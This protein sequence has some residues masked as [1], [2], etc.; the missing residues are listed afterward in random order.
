MLRHLLS[1]F[2]LSRF[3]CRFLDL[4]YQPLGSNEYEESIS[5]LSD[6]ENYRR[7]S[8]DSDSDSDSD[9]L[10][11]EEQIYCSQAKRIKSQN[12]QENFEILYE[13]HNGF[14]S[15]QVSIIENAL[16]IVVDRLFKPEILQNMYQICGKSN[17]FLIHGVL[18]QSN[19]IENSIYF[20]QYL[21]LHYQLMCLKVQCENGEMPIINIY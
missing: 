11:N 2:C 4:C 3:K 8:Y 12:S 17:C 19:L 14:T 13:I 9:I 5:S 20:N 6:C 18:S 1:T 21:L 15:G 10:E 16:Q 7:T